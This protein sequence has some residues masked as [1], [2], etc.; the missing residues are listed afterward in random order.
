[1]RRILTTTLAAGLLGLAMIQPPV[2]PAQSTDPS[3]PSAAEVQARGQIHEAYGEPTRLQAVEGILVDRGPPKP[4]QELP[5]ENK[6]AGDHVSWVSGYWGWDDEAKNFLWV[7]GFWRVMPP[8]RTWVP[9]SWQRVGEGYRWV[10]G[11]WAVA[12]AETQEVMY[13]PP[14][15]ESLDAG[16]SIPA[17]TET[18]VYVPGN[19][20]YQVSR[21]NW[22]PGYWIPRRANWVWVPASYR[23]TPAGYIYVAGYWDRPLLERGLLFAPVRFTRPVYLQPNY[24]YRPAYVIQPDFLC[25]ALFV[26]HGHTG[27]YFGD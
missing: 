27:Y 10:S 5:P 20:I 18:S 8:D 19:W 1:M 22:R 14:P 12:T 2:M 24:V 7:S 23:W 25:G 9:G 13:L 16:P 15:P 26:R 17:P 21:Y 3:P 4:I 6:P 11:Y